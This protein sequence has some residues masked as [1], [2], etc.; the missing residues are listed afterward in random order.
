MNLFRDLNQLPELFRRGAVSVGNFDGVHLGH[1]RIVERLLAVARRVQG[2]AIAFTFDPHP[3]RILRPEAAPAPISWTQRKA[4]LLGQLGVDAVI[5]Y[6][7]DRAFLGLDAREFFDRIL[8]DRLSAK[9][10]VEGPNF[11]FGR[12]RGG[13]IDVLRRLCVEENVILEVVSPLQIG[14]A[15]VSSSR[16]RRLITAGRVEEAQSLLGRPYR[17]RG[18]VVPGARRGA[19][20]GYPTANVGGI[21]TLLPSDGIYAGLAWVDGMSW[22]AAL[23]VGANPTFDETTLKV[24]AYLIGYEG[25]LYERTIEVD[26]LARLRD[27]ERFGS[28]DELVAQVDCDVAATREIVREH[29]G[30]QG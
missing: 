13:T 9:A 1:A 6:P 10:L 23:S 19:K 12:G 21:D 22:P 24:E 18:T 25:S 3:G 4:E 17:I 15:V 26:F 28:V 20:L 5:A 30:Q 29:Q 16:I 8:R 14:D 7:T 2:P 11:F 27:I